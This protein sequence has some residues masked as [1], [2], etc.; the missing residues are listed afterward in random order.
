MINSISKKVTLV[1]LGKNMF[2]DTLK[3]NM[4]KK[5]YGF[6]IFL[7]IQ[8]LFCSIIILPSE[9][10]LVVENQELLEAIESNSL[11]GVRTVFD[12]GI[13]DGGESFKSVNDELYSAF[14]VA[15]DLGCSFDLVKLLGKKTNI[16]FDSI[17]TER[18]RFCTNVLDILVSGVSYSRHGRQWRLRDVKQLRE[19]DFSKK[20]EFC[21]QSGVV[22]ST[23]F[24]DILI[25]A[26][27]RVLKAEAKKSK[28]WKM[29][30][31]AG[32]ACKGKDISAVIAARNCGEVI[33][34]GLGNEDPDIVH[35]VLTA[36]THARAEEL[37]KGYITYPKDCM[38]VRVFC[39]KGRN[40]ISE[41]P[42]EL[43]ALTMSFVLG[44]KIE[45]NRDFF[46]TLWVTRD[47]RS[48]GLFS[49]D[50]L[51]V[52]PSSHSDFD[53]KCD[54]EQERKRALEAASKQAID[55]RASQIRMRQEQRVQGNGVMYSDRVS[56]TSVRLLSSQIVESVYPN[57]ADKKFAVDSAILLS[58]L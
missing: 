50:Q 12:R 51:V 16:H 18:D 46:S 23:Y 42:E 58:K 28:V 37:P 34:M 25:K 1:D 35:R 6:Y 53:E 26:H 41:F 20:V 49:G 21:L 29:L 40:P 47:Q 4:L 36:V 30:E 52:A 38:G 9:M 31:W 24:F 14:G 2:V 27:G 45:N 15:L 48:L 56:P 8:L 55:E 39:N 33:D 19:D 43:V 3:S 22:P 10:T 57:L 32:A 7:V 44:P 17:H 13:V 5:F 54:D 11:D